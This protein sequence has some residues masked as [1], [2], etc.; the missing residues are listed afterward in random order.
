MKEDIDWTI[1]SVSYDPLILYRLIEKS[2]L[3]QTEDQ[4][5]F[6]MVYYQELLLSDRTT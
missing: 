6:T 1:V 4:Y 2:I 5:P 3:A